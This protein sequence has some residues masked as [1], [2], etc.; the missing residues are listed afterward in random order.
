M[1]LTEEQVQAAKAELDRREK[2]QR[3]RYA[4][5]YL[6]RQRAAEERFLAVTDAE[7]PGIDRDTRYGIY[8]AY[9]NFYA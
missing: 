3:E 7:F 1:K 5:E 4:Q 8:A 6:E 9:R 2:E